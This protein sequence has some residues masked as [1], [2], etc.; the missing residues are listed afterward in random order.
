MENQA[1]PWSCNHELHDH[2][3]VHYCDY[4]SLEGLLGLLVPHAASEK[5]RAFEHP[6]EVQFLLVH[7]I[8]EVAFQLHIFELRR[9]ISSL[10]EGD[11][12]VSIHILQRIVGLTKVYPMILSLMNTMEPE[13]FAKFRDKLS[14]ASGAESEASRV[15]ELL[16]GINREA[17][18]MSIHG[19]VLT[20]KQVLD[21]SPAADD[22][23]P[24]PKTRWWTANLEKVSQEPNLADTFENELAKPEAKTGKDVELARIADLLYQYDLAYR[25]YRLTHIGV[26]IRQIGDQ[27]GTGHTD[28]ASYLRSI[29][30]T[31]RFFPTL[32]PERWEEHKRS[33]N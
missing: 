2:N 6:D 14:P 15:I 32:F 19:R 1:T 23:R 4:I 7:Q 22:Y 18:Y 31:V 25:R 33:D 26:V 8:F 9:L 3:Q 12:K 21:Q 5:R 11:Y 24:R 28:G 20:F 30:E 29:A 17:P 10:S 16:S 13:E 27:A